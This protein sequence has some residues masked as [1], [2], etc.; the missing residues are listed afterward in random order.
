MLRSTRKPQR[1]HPYKATNGREPPKIFPYSNG[2]N[3]NLDTHSQESLPIPTPT[4]KVHDSTK[5]SKVSEVKAP[6]ERYA[7]D[8]VIGREELKKYTHWTIYS[9]AKNPERIFFPEMLRDRMT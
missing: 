8:F 5:F 9:N 3:A 4:D 1:S 7:S 2:P 6:I